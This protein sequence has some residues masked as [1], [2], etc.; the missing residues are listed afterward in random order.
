LKYSDLYS[1]EVIIEFLSNNLANNNEPAKE[2][3]DFALDD[4]RQKMMENSR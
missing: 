3:V 2:S 1:I 4:I